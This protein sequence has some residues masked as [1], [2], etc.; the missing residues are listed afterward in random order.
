MLNV[1]DDALHLD[2]SPRSAINIKG[3]LR[4]MY[5]LYRLRGHTPRDC[6][7][8]P[9]LLVRTTCATADEASAISARLKPLL[10]LCVPGTYYLCHR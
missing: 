6:K 10:D 3:Y 5:T 2:D 7:A 8:R 1:V 9:V 4:L